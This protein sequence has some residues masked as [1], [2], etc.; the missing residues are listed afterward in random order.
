MAQLK[1]IQDFFAANEWEPDEG[2]S[3]D[4]HVS[5]DDEFQSETWVR[6]EHNQANTYDSY[7]SYVGTGEGQTYED[8]DDRV[9]ISEYTKGKRVGAIEVEAVID[10][11]D[12]SWASD[13]GVNFATWVR[14]VG[15]AG[16][17]RA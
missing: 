13:S 11:E 8:D 7:G 9:I 15:L 3:S 17:L 14:D 1:E 12:Y 4:G 16:A 10:G 2:G 6:A 5:A